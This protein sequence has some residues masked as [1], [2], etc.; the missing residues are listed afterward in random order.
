MIALVYQYPIGLSDSG[1]L[2]VAPKE[3]MVD[4]GCVQTYDAADS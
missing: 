3:K 4:M 1:G 2:F